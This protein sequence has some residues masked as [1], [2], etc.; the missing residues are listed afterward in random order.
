MLRKIEAGRY[1]IWASPKAIEAFEQAIE[2][3]MKKLIDQ[4]KVI[5]INK[6]E[7]K[8]DEKESPFYSLTGMTVEKA[9]ECIEEAFKKINQ[10]YL[11]QIIK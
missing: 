7:K 5:I 6:G 4:D 11:N 8:S 10:K 3:E 1:I 2:K 9:N